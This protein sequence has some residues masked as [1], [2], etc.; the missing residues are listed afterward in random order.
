M[1]S[2]FADAFWRL[3]VKPGVAALV[4]LVIASRFGSGTRIALATGAIGF[5]FASFLINT[6]YG[7]SLEEA[8]WDGFVRAWRTLIYNLI[9]GL[10]RLVIEIF[11]RIVEHVERYFYAVD[12]WLR[13]REGKSQASLVAKAVL[14]L[15]WFGVAYLARIYVNLLIEPQ[16]NPIKHF[17][18]VTVSH[19]IILPLSV[20]LTKHLSIYLSPYLG[21]WLA[22]IFVGLNV[23]LLPGVFGFL[24]WE[25]KENWR[26]YE[27]NRRPTLGPILVGSHGETISRLLRPGLHS[28]TLPKL[29]AKLRRSELIA[30]EGRLEKRT[31]KQRE[32]LHH[33]EESVRRFLGREFIALLH[34]SRAMKDPGVSLG[35]IELATN[36]IRIELIQENDDHATDPSLWLDLEERQ[37]VL[38]AG[39]SQPGWLDLLDDDAR[40]T[41]DTAIAG[42]FKLSG[43]AIVHTPGDLMNSKDRLDFAQVAISW[44]DW[45]ETWDAEAAAEKL[46]QGCACVLPPC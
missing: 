10:F 38:A 33:V 39:I 32:A 35:S 4:F 45:T 44:D 46:R 34:Q 37:G 2:R 29:Y 13:F 8:V 5:A 3:G 23:L 24:V 11:E 15:F 14:G 22:G 41:L 28:G 19:K 43:V 16:I 30:R 20:E 6:R 17:P 31:I 12:E 9:P 18:V 21:T 36:R 27:A 7:R 25:L 40:Q 1:N 42:L 26:L